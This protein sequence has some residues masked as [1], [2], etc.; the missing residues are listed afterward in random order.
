[1]NP[2]DHAFDA[3]DQTPFFD[4]V[5]ML[6]NQR[7]LRRVSLS[8]VGRLPSPEELSAVGSDGAKAGDTTSGDTKSL[9]KILDAMMTE[10]AFFD[11]LKEAFNDILLVRGFDGNPETVYSYDHFNKTRNW[12]QQYDYSNFPE[13]DRLKAKYRLTDVYREAI[14]REPLELIAHIVRNNRPITELVTADYIMVSPYTARGYGIYETLKPKF[15]DPDDP[16]EYI[17]TKLPALKNRSGKVQESKT[18][19][20]PHGIVEH[21]S[22]LETLSNH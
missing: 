3:K 16:Y 22:L 21:V 17:V 1:V 7:L 15:K 4:G 11:R 20:Y 9:N 5:V 10:P 18:G 19:F 8:L 13:K 14:L 12:P 6:S 2:A